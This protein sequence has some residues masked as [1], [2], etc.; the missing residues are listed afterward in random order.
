MRA[1]IGVHMAVGQMMYHL[2]SGPSLIAVSGA[3]MLVGKSFDQFIKGG[4]KRFNASDAS[5]QFFRAIR[6]LRRESTVG[7]SKGVFIHGWLQRL[8]FV[9]LSRGY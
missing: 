7:I 2:A 9:G 6:W 1:D 8:F 3:E 5:I 4:G